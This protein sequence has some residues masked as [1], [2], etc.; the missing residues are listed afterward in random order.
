MSAPLDVEG[1]L[2]FERNG[3]EAFRLDA[4]GALV[5]ARF[6]RLSDAWGLGRRLRSAL[7]G[8]VASAEVA[9]SA[10]AGAGLGLEIRIGPHLVARAGEGVSGSW[11]ARLLRLG[12]VELQLDGILRAMFGR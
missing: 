10:L 12:A 11:L 3:V 9:T 4:E 6:V 8:R 7:V 2:V 5:H 1:S